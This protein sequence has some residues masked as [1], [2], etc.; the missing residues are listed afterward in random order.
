MHR[1]GINY[2]DLNIQDDCTLTTIADLPDKWVSIKNQLINSQRNQADLIYMNYLTASQG[3]FPYTVAS[4][5]LLPYTR[6]AQLWTG[7]ASVDSNGDFD[8]DSCWDTLLFGTVC[9][10]YYRGTNMIFLNQ[11]GDYPGKVGI[12]MM[13]FPGGDLISAIIAKNPKTYY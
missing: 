3:V 6:S 4:G 13:D 11:L 8:S 7:R 9:S 10:L 5:K 2:G 1:W 12:I